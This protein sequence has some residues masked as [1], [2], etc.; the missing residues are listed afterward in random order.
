[1]MLFP[2]TKCI[3]TKRGYFTD[4]AFELYVDFLLDA[5][6]GGIPDNGRWRILIVD[7]YGLHTMVPSVLEKLAKKKK[8]DMCFNAFRYISCSAASRRQLFQANSVFLVLVS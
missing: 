6:H 4:E 8:C 3:P 7:G 5:Q 1:M 2:G